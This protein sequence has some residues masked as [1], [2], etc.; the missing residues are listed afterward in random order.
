MQ[1]AP[2]P[3]NSCK[4]LLKR[5]AE[6]VDRDH[7]ESPSQRS[8]LSG[9]SSNLQ[10]ISSCL[11]G[12]GGHSKQSDSHS[13]GDSFWDIQAVGL[14]RYVAQ[15]VYLPPG[16]SPTF[17]EMASSGSQG[18]VRGR[19]SFL[20]PRSHSDCGTPLNGEKYRLKDSDYEKI[21]SY[22]E[23]PDN[24]AALVGGGRRTR[25][26]AKYQSKA[27]VIR[28]ML[29]AIQH[30][31][32]PDFINATNFSKRFQ[33]YVARYK[34]A[35]VWRTTTGN[36]L[37]EEEI[38]QGV[39]MDDKLNRMC[40]HF[41]KMHAIYGARP[42]VQPALEG[43]VGV[44]D[45]DFVY[46][47]EPSDENEPNQF[48]SIAA[49]ENANPNLHQRNAD[50]PPTWSP[51]LQSRKS[52]GSRQSPNLQPR[53][54]PTEILDNAGSQSAAESF[55]TARNCATHVAPTCTPSTLR[56]AAAT[57]R[58]WNE[59]EEMA[60]QPL[61]RHAISCQ[62]DICR[63]FAGVHTGESR[64]TPTTSESP[65]LPTQVPIPPPR[66]PPAAPIKGFKTPGQAA[67]EAAEHKKPSFASVFSE[68]INLKN[69]FCNALI[70][71]KD[72][73]KTE[74]ARERK[75]ALQEVVMQQNK[76]RKHRL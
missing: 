57:E 5:S 39:T 28:Q 11:K 59:L 4:R 6:S 62:C 74:E 51:G 13:G 69:D 9:I 47:D 60:N 35:Q 20:A 34:E 7:C 12:Q 19:A 17:S 71:S 44:N 65:S 3:S 73:W 14:D 64:P 48:D 75:E 52:P 15:P 54:S 43:D 38:Q 41:H 36:G 50:I 40:P 1:F 58:M 24:F 10:V 2:S 66:P 68:K 63:A 45:E 67:K 37:S 8:T 70:Q 56:R 32:F 26:G 23:I 42:N 22:L 49:Q 18:F 27:V 25:V 72:K 33:R 16:L 76:E 31:G 29:V 21:V 61:P 55:H 46:P 30:N 53:H